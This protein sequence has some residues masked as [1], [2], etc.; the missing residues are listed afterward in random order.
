MAIV[1]EKK[2]VTKEMVFLLIL[3]FLGLIF[4]FH[5][6]KGYRT[7]QYILPPTFQ[8]PQ[9]DFDFLRKEIIKELTLFQPV[10]LLPLEE[11]GRENPFLAY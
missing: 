6:L 3:F 11:A 8:L 5:I 7:E 2:I 4:L 9:V 10:A 1:F